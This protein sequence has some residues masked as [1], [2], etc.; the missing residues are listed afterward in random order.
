MSHNSFSV[1]QQLQKLVFFLLGMRN[2][3][4]IVQ[5]QQFLIEKLTVYLVGDLEKV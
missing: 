2:L 3:S 4:E 5:F 1:H